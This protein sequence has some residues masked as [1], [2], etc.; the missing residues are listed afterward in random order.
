[1]V[2]VHEDAVGLDGVHEDGHAARFA[3]ARLAKDEGGHA[4][5]FGPAG[6]AIAG[7]GTLRDAREQTSLGTV[8][9]DGAARRRGWERSMAV[10][11]V[12]V[13]ALRAERTHA[14]KRTLVR[15]LRTTGSAHM[16]TKST[17]ACGT[18]R[19]GSVDAIAANAATCAR[20]GQGCPGDEETEES[21][22]EDRIEVARS[23]H[24]EEDA[25]VELGVVVVRVGRHG[26]D[27]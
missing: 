19:D 2:L 25:G 12:A 22:G 26:G 11:A 8:V 10:A 1:M 7:I 3:A 23:L 6:V 16:K 4:R 14:A 13:W 21:V 20:P 27:A 17:F 18:A 9:G 15:Q 5:R 24:R